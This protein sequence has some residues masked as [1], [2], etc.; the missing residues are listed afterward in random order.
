[1]SDSFQKVISNLGQI[2]SRV[3]AW[4]RFLNPE[5]LEQ[6][7]RLKF[8]PLTDLTF[9]DTE[10]ILE[11]TLSEEMIIP[12]LRNMLLPGASKDIEFNRNN[13]FDKRAWCEFPLPLF[14]AGGGDLTLKIAVPK[15]IA[16]SVS[17]FRL[18]HQLTK[19]RKRWGRLYCVD[20]R[21]VGAQNGF[22][23]Q[24]AENREFDKDAVRAIMFQQLFD[25]ATKDCDKQLITIS[26]DELVDAVIRGN[27]KMQTAA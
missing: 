1:M 10:I 2:R 21:L 24:V 15:P 14:I 7:D 19:F 3:L 4:Q 23:Q 26:D 25:K 11:T 27:V 5:R 17:S 18:E 20:R 8:H 6:F 13:F 22:K 9:R 16:A 12:A